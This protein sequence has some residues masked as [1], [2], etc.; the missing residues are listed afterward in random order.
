[1]VRT[2]RT[3][4][5]SADDW[6]ECFPL[7][8]IGG[9]DEINA[10]TFTANGDYLVTGGSKGVRAWRV[11]DG[12]QMATL[13]A[14]DAKCLAVS[15]DG[16]WIAA[17]T[18]GMGVFVWDAKTYEQVLAGQGMWLLPGR[19]IYTVDFSPDSTRLV[20]A[21]GVRRTATIWNFL[22]RKE[23]HTLHHESSVYVAKYSQD[24]G[25][26][27][28][29][30]EDSVLV[31][32][33]DD[34]HLLAHIQVQMILNLDTIGLR[35]SNDH[36]FVI[37]ARKIEQIDVSTGSTVLRW[38]VPKGSAHI[39]MQHLPLITY[40]ARDRDDVMFW[41]T[42][43]YTHHHLAHPPKDIC[44]IALSPDGRLLAIATGDGMVTVKP[45]LPHVT[46]SSLCCSFAWVPESA[47]FLQH[48]SPPSTIFPCS[49]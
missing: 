11:R 1:M 39:A 34:G 32:D 26:I 44:S 18:V 40:V 37:S 15:T 48:G 25:R 29:A 16:R 13:E 24:G 17:G 10:T 2:D 35:W 46:V 49:V 5:V 23:V 43:K 36:L 30:G 42:S 6:K 21:Q 3:D 28:T 12:M 7:I 8:G 41:D 38:P 27:A 9:G 22:A 47:H 19:A 4:R 31:W 14:W 20:V 33:S 45:L